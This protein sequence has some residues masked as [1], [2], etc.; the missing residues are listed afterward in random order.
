MKQLRDT[1]KT[2]L[3]ADCY[4]A[5]VIGSFATFDT[6]AGNY[7]IHTL[8]TPLDSR[9]S[10]ADLRSRLAR[11]EKDGALLNVSWEDGLIYCI[12]DTFKDHL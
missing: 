10:F 4:S 8:P 7:V 3:E 6:R 11:R 1:G 5:H 12:M 2:D 9:Y